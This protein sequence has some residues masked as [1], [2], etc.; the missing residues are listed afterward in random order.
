VIADIPVD[1]GREEAADLARAE[2]ADPIYAQSQPPLLQ[3]ALGWLLERIQE[4]ID[5][6]V[7]AAPGGW[8]GILGIVALVVLAVV[9]VRWRVATLARSHAGTAAL[10]A[11]APLDA[12]EHRARAERLAA[13]GAWAEAVRERLR[14]LVRGLEEAGI[15]DDRPGRTADEAAREAGR[16]LPEHAQALA[17]ATRTFD[18]VWYGDRPAGAAEY[19]AVA[20]ADARVG[21]ARGASTRMTV[22]A[23]PMGGPPA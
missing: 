13:Q 19:A 11:G 1:L 17:R 18:D 3:R 16:A 7:D 2:L 22:P 6:V 4:G 5:R 14:A 9:A 20:D 12:A 23:A 10:F 15:L 8:L 21:G